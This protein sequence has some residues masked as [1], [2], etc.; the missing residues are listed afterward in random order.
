[1]KP[2]L[3]VL[4][5]A[6][7]LSTYPISAY[8]GDDPILTKEQRKAVEKAE[9]LRKQYPLW[10]TVEES[11]IDGMPAQVI[12]YVGWCGGNLHWIF[13]SSSPITTE[14]QYVITR[15][16]WEQTG[17]EFTMRCPTPN[18]RNHCSVLATGRYPARKLG[19]SHWPDSIAIL[20]NVDQKITVITFDSKHPVNSLK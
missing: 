6:L 7:G 3:F 2:M 1:M 8:S 20:G 12:G 9:K 18:S 14:G 5:I 10:L 15:A 4:G 17:E 16:K 11:N 19:W 13:C